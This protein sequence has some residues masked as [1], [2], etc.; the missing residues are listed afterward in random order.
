MSP[1]GLGIVHVPDVNLV[2]TNQRVDLRDGGFIA[3]RGDEVVSGDVGVAG[4]KADSDRRDAREAADEFANL[5]KGASKENS[6]PAVFSMR[7]RKLHCRRQAPAMAASIDSAASSNPCSRAR[8]FHEPGCSTRYS[9]PSASTALD[10]AAKGG[11]RV[12]ADFFGL[13]AEVDEI[14]GVND[15]RRA[16]I[17]CA[18]PLHLVA[19]GGG[20]LRGTPHARA[21]GKYLKS[22]GA[23]CLGAFGGGEDPAGG[24]E[25]HADSFR[26][27][28]KLRIQVRHILDGRLAVLS[29]KNSE[30][31]A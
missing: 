12:A 24:R 18:Q 31:F 19:V 29:K 10:L 22:V 20:D 11:D 17:F 4:V 30:G 6:A 27:R 9:A 21:G 8:P 1:G 25:V 2:Q 7:M 15:Q 13:A 3:I 23:H 16:V 5:I 14:A 26:R 28:F